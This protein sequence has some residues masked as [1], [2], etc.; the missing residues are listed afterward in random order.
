MHVPHPGV[1]ELDLEPN[2]AADM[3]GIDLHLV[4]QIEAPLGLH[5]KL[6]H[7]ENVPILLVELQFHLG[8]VLLEVLDAHV[9]SSSRSNSSSRSSPRP[10][11]WTK[12]RAIPGPETGPWSGNPSTPKK[13]RRWILQGPYCFNAAQCS[14]V[15]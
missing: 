15:P 13:E 1:G 2:L 3:F 10:V 4:R 14:L 11:P 7:R 6:E 12:S 9:I 8:L 5:D